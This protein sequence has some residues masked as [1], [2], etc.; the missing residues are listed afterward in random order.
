[1]DING[2]FNVTLEGWK[3]WKRF[4]FRE[5]RYEIPPPPILTAEHAECAEFTI[6]VIE[7]GFVAYQ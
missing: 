5:L 6:L 4:E 1:M 3:M 2:N 7:H